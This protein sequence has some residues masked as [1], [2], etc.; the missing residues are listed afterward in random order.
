MVE[1]IQITDI[2]EQ[3]VRKEKELEFYTEELKKLQ[4]KMFFIQKDIDVTN[5]IIKIIEQ[6]TVLDIKSSMENRMIKKT[7]D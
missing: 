3:K 2:L 7:D 4:M 5:T 6:E 1:L